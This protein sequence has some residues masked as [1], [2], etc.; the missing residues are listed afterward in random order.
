MSSPS[1][2]VSGIGELMIEILREDAPVHASMLPVTV[3][4]L[5]AEYLAE[6][7][8]K[9]PR[10]VAVRLVVEPAGCSGHAY[11][12]EPA[13]VIGDEDSVFEEHG[14]RIVINAAVMPYLQ[15]TRLDLKHQGLARRV[16]FDNPNARE[17]CGCG[18]SFGI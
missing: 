14:L 7:L 16:F 12:I 4:E 15:G 8:A 18:E 1:I 5:A 11:R 13:E 6:Q 17:T 2:Q 10:A 9:H 3:S